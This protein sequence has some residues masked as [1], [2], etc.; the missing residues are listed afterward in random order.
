[1]AFLWK[2]GKNVEW[3]MVNEPKQKNHEVTIAKWPLRAYT[4]GL[5]NWKKNR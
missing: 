2:P 1:V 3:K 4:V 5:K